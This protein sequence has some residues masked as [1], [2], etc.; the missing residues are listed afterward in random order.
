MSYILLGIYYRQ[1]SQTDRENAG[2]AANVA[3]GNATAEVKRD[4]VIGRKM[5]RIK[6]MNA[7][8]YTIYVNR[9]RVIVESFNTFNAHL[10]SFPGEPIWMHA[11][12]DERGTCI[13][14]SVH[15]LYQGSDED[16]VALAAD[17][18]TT[19]QLEKIGSRWCELGISSRK[20]LEASDHDLSYVTIIHIS[21]Y[22]GCCL[23]WIDRLER[24]VTHFIN[25][26][27]KGFWKSGNEMNIAIVNVR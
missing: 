19:C 10:H 13:I 9:H 27:P 18:T 17:I 26:Y 1:F 12:A 7:F 20:Q 15:P 22:C 5:E 14:Y 23:Y 25:S 6:S 3:C 16:S 11:C 4:K 2:V 8:W 24:I 21:L